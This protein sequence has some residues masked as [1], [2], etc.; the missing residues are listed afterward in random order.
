MWTKLSKKVLVIMVALN[1]RDE[2]SLNDT[3]LARPSLDVWIHTYI[4]RNLPPTGS[5]VERRADLPFS[6]TSKGIFRQSLLTLYIGRLLNN[7]LFEPGNDYYKLTYFHKL[8][9]INPSLIKFSKLV[10]SI[11]FC[12]TVLYECLWYN[13][14]FCSV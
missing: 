10:L 7:N 8:L 14:N 9:F 4:S 1:V 11:N 5:K 2:T 3:A 6:G 13:L 12:L